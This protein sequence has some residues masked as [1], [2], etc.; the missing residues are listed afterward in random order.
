MSYGRGPA[1]NTTINTGPPEC[2]ES[3]IVVEPKPE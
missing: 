1:P 3:L 2:R